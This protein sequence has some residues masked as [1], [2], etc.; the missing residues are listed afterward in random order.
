MKITIVLIHCCTKHLLCIC[1]AIA[2]G[3][4]C[5]LDAADTDMCAQRVR[6]RQRERAARRVAHGDAARVVAA[7][8]GHDFGHTV[9][10]G[11]RVQHARAAHHTDQLL[12][13]HT[14]AHVSDSA[15]ARA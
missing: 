7:Q 2:C 13:A 5:W 3:W 6:R 8:L 1:R 9:E 12:P 11:T 15:A 4:R 10:L 14:A